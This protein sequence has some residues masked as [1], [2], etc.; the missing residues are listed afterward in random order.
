MSFIELWR[1]EP[2]QLVQLIIPAEAAHDT[3]FSLGEL[4]LLQFR[5]LNV[6]KNAFQ[7]TYANQ[8]KR[9]EEMAR[10]LR[11]FEDQVEKA[12]IAPFQASETTV[13]NFDELESRLDDLEKELLEINNNTERL[14]KN[15]SELYELQLVLERAGSFFEE[16][17]GRAYT[18]AF[19]RASYGHPQGPEI[20]SS[21][22]ESADMQEIAKSV[23]LGFVAGIVEQ[24]KLNSF[25][26]LLFRVTRG[27]M[28]LR[29][30]EVGTVVD[31]ATGESKQ[32]S[33]FV[34]FFAGDRARVKINKICETFGANRYPFPEDQTRQRQMTQ[35]VTA[36]LRELQTTIEAGGRH[37]DAVLGDL[38]AQLPGWMDLVK[39]EKGVYHNLNKMSVDVT[40][41]A[42][43]AEAWTP[44]EAR[45]QIQEALQAATNTSSAA[46]SSIFQTLVTHEQPPTYY[47]THMFNAG[48]QA[49]VDAYGVA[50]YREV[51]PATWTIITFPFL[52]AVMFGDFGHA[53]LMI[54]FALALIINEKKMLKQQLNDM[55]EMAFSGRYVI[56]LMGIFSV[57]TGLMYNEFFSMPVDIFQTQYVCADDTTLEDPRD[58]NRCESAFTD[59][60]VLN[61]IG[62][63]YA[64]GVDPVWHGFETK[65]ELPFTNSVK[66]KM[67][68]VL[69]VAQM[70]LGILM[71][72]MN[73][74]YFQDMLSI[75]CE[76]IPQI[77]FLWSV[78][79]Y[80]VFLI[81]YKWVA[82]P[83]LNDR[84]TSMS[85]N[86]NATA[87]DPIGRPP[88]LY[89]IMISFFL[90]PGT[91]G[92]PDSAETPKCPPDQPDC[93]CPNDFGCPE[94]F[95]FDGQGGVQAVLLLIA[96]LCIPWML[97]P[98]PLILR[99]RHNKA[100]KEKGQYGMLTGS[101]H[102]QL[103][104][105]DEEEEQESHI[106]ESGGG[107]GG[108]G[109][110]EE[111]VFGEVMVHQ[112]IHT[113]EFVLGAVSNTASYLRLWALS[114]AHSQLSAV[115]YSKVLMQASTASLTPGTSTALAAVY[116][117]VGYF[118]WAFATIGV[119][120]VMESLSAF[121][122]ALRLHW[123][124]FQ[125][126]FY[127]GDGYPFT[128]FSFE[129]ILQE[130]I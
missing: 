27:N 68:I 35:E 81:I 44:V 69:G 103:P 65:T 13:S 98:K 77:L 101:S 90:S 49:I 8:V 23:K 88:D 95:I 6:E 41:K 111:F 118:V 38:A 48:F 104:I 97:L 17:R 31:P 56:L 129:T 67:S 54:A 79:G 34:V 22:L 72:L 125:N 62:K 37:R 99:S 15:H 29:T 70:S 78:F 12:K 119:L 100:L 94:S 123:V 61:Q 86:Y 124:E 84:S 122:H 89:G 121:L 24:E 82:W 113:I 4:G 50:R 112:M 96:F 52:F 76:F 64:F 117:F 25:E 9:C 74:L 60:L 33:V 51:N 20:R 43:V 26:R 57:F 55:V 128:P 11:F 127:H 105:D 45:E 116:L 58:T 28:F 126:K 87:Y 83:T 14:I 32:K 47:H 7:R 46:V 85:C 102:H 10:K 108:H 3:V 93:T 36:R 18:G 39:K 5:D 21:L 66:M 71:S 130:E 40:K 42:L 115:F 16:A 73:Q 109:H 110:G 2:V 106:K 107:H 92:C 19:E 1:S 30:V 91:A 75:L 63:P 53:A 114:L 59:G 120:M 80:M